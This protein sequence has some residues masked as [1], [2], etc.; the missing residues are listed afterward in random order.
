M[1]MFVHQIHSMQKIPLRFVHIFS[2]NIFQ[3][4]NVFTPSDEKFFVSV[5]QAD[6]ST[7]AFEIKRNAFGKW[8]IVEPAP[9]WVRKNEDEIVESLNYWIHNLKAA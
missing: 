9:Y 2:G 3:F 7:V 1:I 6:E 5:L 8:K 4:E